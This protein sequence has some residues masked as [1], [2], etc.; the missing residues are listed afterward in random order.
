VLSRLDGERNGDQEVVV[1]LA[2]VDVEAEPLIGVEGRAGQAGLVPKLIES[3][4]VF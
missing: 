4:G 1:A 3:S 2:R